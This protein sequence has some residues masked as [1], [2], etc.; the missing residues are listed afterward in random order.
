MCPATASHAIAAAAR[1]RLIEKQQDVTPT[2]TGKVGRFSPHPDAGVALQP[3][4]TDP[5][6]LT[7][8]RAVRADFDP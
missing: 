6:G 5:G 1:P 7:E 2:S 3:G 4:K 8:I